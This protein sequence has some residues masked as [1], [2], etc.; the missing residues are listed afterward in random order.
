MLQFLYTTKIKPVEVNVNFHM[1]WK[2]KKTTDTFR[3]RLN[4]ILLA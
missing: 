3:G 1:P 4:L 2:H